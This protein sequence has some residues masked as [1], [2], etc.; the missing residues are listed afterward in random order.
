MEDLV[1]DPNAEELHELQPLFENGLWIFG[2]EYESIEY[3]S[4]KTL[5][6]II[7]K[8]FKGENEIE[9]PKK[10]PDFIALPDRSIGVYSRDD[11][12]RWRSL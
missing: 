1:E 9:H 10:R 11:F 3:L 6:T 5:A 2:P 12:G 7:K 4:N 8:F